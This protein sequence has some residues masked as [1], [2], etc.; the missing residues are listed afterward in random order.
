MKKTIPQ[1]R[2]K[3]TVQA[4]KAAREAAMNASITPAK[5]AP[6]APDKPDTDGAGASATCE[7]DPAS[8]VTRIRNYVEQE[9]S[10]GLSVVHVPTPSNNMGV[11]EVS[12]GRNTSAEYDGTE[13]IAIK[14]KGKNGRYSLILVPGQIE[15]VDSRIGFVDQISFTLYTSAVCKRETF[16]PFHPIQGQW[17]EIDAVSRVSSALLEIFGFGVTS[18]LDKGRNFYTHS[19]S[20]GDYAEYGAVST[21][22]NNNGGATASTINVQITGQG[23]L[24]AAEG[25]QNRLY[26][27]L[28]ATNGHISRIDIAAD[29]YQGQYSP[30]QAKQDW[31]QGKYSLTNRKPNI[32]LHGG[33]WWNPQSDA[34]KTI[35]IGTREGGKCTRVYQKGLEQLGKIG[36]K[37][38][39]DSHPL[40]HLK[41]WVRIETEWHRTNRVLP[42]DMLLEPGK[43]LAG[44]HPAALGFLDEIQVKIETVKRKAVATVERAKQVFIRQMG[45]TAKALQELGVWDDV[46]AQIDRAKLPRWV[47]GFDSPDPLDEKWMTFEKELA[48]IPF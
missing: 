24:I 1:N 29:L 28:D 41:K 6:Q 7:H 10:G 45:S 21:G 2:S 33:S 12:I 14:P 13:L 34:G 25:W 16:Y 11:T 37:M 38:I 30:E 36:S 46:Q 15:G 27:Y 23:C 35:T 44:S 18:Q 20:L 26:N 43:Y 19:Y 3:S 5:Y 42:L 32:Q 48:M 47:M 39:D 17:P 40:N 9:I 4:S 31:E 22:G 8:S